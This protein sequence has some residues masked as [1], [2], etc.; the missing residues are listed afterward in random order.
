MGRNNVL[1]MWIAVMLMTVMIN[2]GRVEDICNTSIPLMS[3][4][5][6]AVDGDPT[7]QCC[8]NIQE[9]D[10]QLFSPG[11]SDHS[12]LIVTM[13]TLGRLRKSGFRFYNVWC[14]HDKLLEIVK[15]VWDLNVVG[16]KMFQVY[17]KMKILR[18]FL[19][20]LNKSVFFDI[21]MRV[22]ATRKMLA[23]L[24]ENLILNLGN[25]ILQEEE[26]AISIH[27]F[28]LIRW[29]EDILRQKSRAT[30]INLGD[31]NTKFFHNSIKQRQ[32][33]KNTSNL[34][35]RDG[36]LLIDDDRIEM[37]KEVTDEEIKRSMFSINGDKA[38][39]PDG[40]SSE[41]FK[42]S[43]SIVGPCVTLGI[44]DF[45][46]TKKLLNQ[47]NLP[48]Y[49]GGLVRNTQSAFIP[50]RSIADNVLVAHEIVN[51]YHKRAGESCAMKIDVRKAYD[52]IGW[53]FVELLL[54]G[55]RFSRNMVET[56]MTC[57]R[58]V[59]YSIMVNGEAI[60]YFCNIP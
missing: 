16:Y 24:Q 23:E 35:L 12:A 54:Y 53:D 37:D 5:L 44:I 57:V 7:T 11:V 27:L 14:K 59:K 46:S 40:F 25:N 1:A 38:L 42:K 55:F 17:N 41:F 15:D 49:I 47:Q 60:G 28:K 8:L 13:K 20:Q 52:S 51:N 19:R 21:S 43:W 6:S 56:I 2:G 39:G 36:H 33:R 9:A 26:R 3:E 31:Q 45:F 29:E 58:S 50:G 22:D 32:T 30:W 4:C 10:L 34:F 48:S 18:N